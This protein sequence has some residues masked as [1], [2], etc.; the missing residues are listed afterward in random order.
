MHPRERPT[1]RRQFLIRAGVT[2]GALS[3]SLGGLAQAV[4]VV[5]IGP[6]IGAI[7]I[8]LWAPETR[9]LK[10]ETISG[11]PTLEPVATE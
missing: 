10:L 5:C 9:G 3:K 6:V 4:S 2:V 7:V 1:T 8:M 11:S